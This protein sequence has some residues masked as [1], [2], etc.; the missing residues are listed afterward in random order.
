MERSSQL[1]TCVGNPETARK[2]GE[3]KG[4]KFLLISL[5][6]LFGYFPTEI[7]LFSLLLPFWPK[8]IG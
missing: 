6:L 2:R 1:P 3:E 8:A 5:S 7:H 4:K